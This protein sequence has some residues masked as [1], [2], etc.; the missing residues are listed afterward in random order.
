MAE[1]APLP[2]RAEWTGYASIVLF[3]PRLVDMAVGSL[4]GDLG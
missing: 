3:A 1:D 2:Q 4:T